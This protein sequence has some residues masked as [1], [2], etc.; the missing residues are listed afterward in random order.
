MKYREVKVFAIALLLQTSVT[1]DC[2]FNNI[3]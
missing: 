3:Y 2:E 1:K